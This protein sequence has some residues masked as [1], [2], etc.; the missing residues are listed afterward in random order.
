MQ[1]SESF[2]FILNCYFFCCYK[3]CRFNNEKSANSFSKKFAKTFIPLALIGRLYRPGIDSVLEEEGRE[4][5]RRMEGMKD[6][7]MDGSK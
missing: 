3:I 2:I 4:G 7:W 6:V 5:K 1:I